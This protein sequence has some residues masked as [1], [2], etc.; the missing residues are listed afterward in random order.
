[1]RTKAAKNLETF[2]NFSK[3]PILTNVFPYKPTAFGNDV[4]TY[5][6]AGWDKDNDAMCSEILGIIKNV[7]EQLN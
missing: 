5:M 3:W 6:D 1:M 4:R 2:R 7:R